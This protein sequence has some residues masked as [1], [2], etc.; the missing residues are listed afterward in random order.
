MSRSCPP[1]WY[2]ETLG[3]SLHYY[4]RIENFIYQGESKFQKIDVVDTC[5][6]GRVLFLDEKIQ[7]A[8]IDEFIYHEML[9]HPAMLLHPE[10]KKVLIIGGGEGATLREVLNHPSVEQVVMV[11]IDEELVNICERY[12]EKWHRGAFS[13]PRSKVIFTDAR[14]YIFET[15]EKFDVVISDLT[16]PLEEGPSIYLFTREFYERVFQILTDDGVF[17]AQA[18]SADIFYYNL[19]VILHRTLKEVF[20]FVDIYLTFMMSFQSLWSFVIATKHQ[21]P[22]DV[23]SDF[24]TERIRTRNLSLK[25]FYPK[26][27]D[28][29][30]TL[31]LYLIEELKKPGKISTDKEPFIWEKG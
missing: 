11:D 26:F 12:L 10:P 14:K 31:P 16:E 9:V 29:M 24:F 23:N 15:D 3:D 28:R 25:F 13:D 5:E 22:S 20:P 8:E 1:S 27:T 19:P 6:F 18:G 2:V 17:V 7:S 30:F 4:Y 21:S